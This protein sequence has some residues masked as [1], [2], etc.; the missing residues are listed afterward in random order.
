VVSIWV[1]KWQPLA[2]DALHAAAAIFA[3]A[4]VAV[5]PT[6]VVARINDEVSRET[7]GLFAAQG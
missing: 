4:P 2:C 5:D 3:E 1:D 6:A 7:A